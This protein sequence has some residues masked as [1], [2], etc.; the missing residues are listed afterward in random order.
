M[1]WELTK[2]T[3]YLPL[4]YLQGG[5]K[6][7]DTHKVGF[8]ERGEVFLEERVCATTDHSDIN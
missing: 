5:K 1:E 2:E 4:G 7:K 6:G 3:I 8:A